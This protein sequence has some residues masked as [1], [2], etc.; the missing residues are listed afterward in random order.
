MIAM[1]FMSIHTGYN[2]GFA[3]T[4]LAP[5]ETECGVKSSGCVRIELESE[6]G[7]Y[8]LALDIEDARLLAEQLPALVMAHDAAEHVRKEQA[9]AIAEAA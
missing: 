4:Y 8:A 2:K 9:A 7:I 1:S 6:M 3:L 5:R